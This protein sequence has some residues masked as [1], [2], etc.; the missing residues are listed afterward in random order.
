MSS[1]IGSLAD[2]AVKGD[3]VPE[4]SAKPNIIPS[5]PAPDQ[6]TQTLPQGQNLADAADGD[7][8]IPRSAA[9]QGATGEVTTGT[10][11][12]LPASVEQKRLGVDANN[13]AAK[14]HARDE[15][16]SS[17]RTSQFDKLAGEGDEVDAAPGEEKESQESL[18]DKRES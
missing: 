16:H 6:D 10:G 5:V 13:P 4:D 17:G 1:E 8:D 14:G 15:K 12:L 11:D 7:R 2:M 9:D 18:R 3:H